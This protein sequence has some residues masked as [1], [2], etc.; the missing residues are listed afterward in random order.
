ME[1]NDTG[2]GA[3]LSPGQ[4]CPVC[5]RR[6]PF[7]KT[8]RSPQTKKKGYWV[9]IDEHEGHEDVLRAAAEFLGCADQPFFEFKTVT[10]ALAALL[11]DESL[12]GYAKS[13]WNDATAGVPTSE[14]SET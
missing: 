6:V 5:E 14:T 11:Q 4:D 1:G 13:A 2:T 8:E 7:P 10:I 3:T 12:R 9:P